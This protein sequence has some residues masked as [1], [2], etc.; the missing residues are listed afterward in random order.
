[1]HSAI[2]ETAG[3]WPP[4]RF[5]LTGFRKEL[6]VSTLMS[7]ALYGCERPAMFMEIVSCAPFSPVKVGG[8][9]G[10]ELEA[11]LATQAVPK[12]VTIP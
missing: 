8:V 2:R 3:S 11:W 12:V 9:E 10:H 4:V 6:L 7:K 5:T 1:M